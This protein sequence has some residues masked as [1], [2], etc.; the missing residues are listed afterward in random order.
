MDAS[1]KDLFKL[2]GYQSV[3]QSNLAGKRKGSGLA[4]YI[5]D[6]LFYTTNEELSQCSKNL[7]SLFISVSNTSEPVTIGVVYRPPSG[8][9]SEF[10]N[11]LN[12]LRTRVPKCNVILTSDFNIDLHKP[13][14]ADFEDAIYGNGFVPL[15][16]IATHFKPGCNPSC[17][18]NV[19]TNSVD[20]I[21]MSGVCENTVS[22]HLLTYHFFLFY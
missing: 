7:E 10:I 18:D 11:E 1:N 22:H 17:I 15:V 4:I 19:F 20:N 2:H 5:K 14:I 9:R 12:N 8:D 21:R 13:N 6:S 16:S 3:Y